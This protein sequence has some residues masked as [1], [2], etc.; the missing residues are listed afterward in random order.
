MNGQIFIS[1]RRDESS[2]WAGRLY[3]GLSRKFISNQLFIDVDNLEPGVDF[4]EAIEASVGACDALIAVIGKRWLICSDEA[5]NRRLDNPVD[6]VRLEISTAFKRKI[7]VIPV[8]VDGALM[9]SSI[10]LPDDLKPLVRRNALDVSHHRFN[11]DLRRLIDALERILEKTD[12]ERKR[13]GEKA[14]LGAEQSEAVHPPP[15]KKSPMPS[16]GRGGK[17]L[18]KLVI[19]VLTTGAVLVAG[20]LSRHRSWPR[21]Q[22]PR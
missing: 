22:V 4:V 16:G 11:A 7:R 6:F 17:S 19:T 20:G 12:A 21:R 8:L 15:R 13:R 10:D 2:A 3:D 14:C 1:Y 9:P 5:G 18:S